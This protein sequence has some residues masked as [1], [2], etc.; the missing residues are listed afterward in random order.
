MRLDCVSISAVASA[1]VSF[2]IGLN[3]PF[4]FHVKHLFD[5]T[6]YPTQHF[7]RRRAGG[8]AFWRGRLG[9]TQIWVSREDHVSLDDSLKP[10]CPT[11]NWH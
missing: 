2:F 5:P 3:F 1:S 8:C 6:Y 7:L 4:V 11:A 10:I 9:P